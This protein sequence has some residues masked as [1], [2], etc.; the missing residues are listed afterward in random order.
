MSTSTEHLPGYYLKDEER[1]AFGLG[2]EHCRRGL[3]IS[4]NPFDR[5]HWKWQDYRDGWMAKRSWD[6]KGKTA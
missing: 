3:P 1:C 4:K 5:S 2:Y 6:L